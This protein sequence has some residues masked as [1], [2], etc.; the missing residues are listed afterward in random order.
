MGHIERVD[1]KLVYE[2]SILKI[3]EDTM[4]A[5]DGRKVK[6]DF[7]GHQGAA[8]VV[9]VR[10]DGKILMVRQF[11]NSLDR[12]TLEIPAGCRDYPEEPTIDCAYRELQEETGYHA[13][14]M[15]FL[16]RVCSAIAFC[17]EMIDIYVA[18]DLTPGS[19][20]LDPDEMIDVEG[21]TIDELAEMIYQGKIN[22]SKTVA[23]LMAYKNKY[24]QKENHI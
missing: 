1:R 7:I 14:K 16:I 18:S 10:N 2:G 11:R 19:Q 3:Y 20:H 22:D 17:D 15:E 8:A 5:E 24:S 6:W 9:P 21:Y 23:A 12:M 4:L 13:G